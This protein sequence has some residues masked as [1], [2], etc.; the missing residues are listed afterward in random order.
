MVNLLSELLEILRKSPQ[1]ENAYHKKI[2]QNQYAI[3]MRD[4]LVV[5][6]G[7]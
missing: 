4:L 5:P 2:L 6:S 1:L 7:A 3:L